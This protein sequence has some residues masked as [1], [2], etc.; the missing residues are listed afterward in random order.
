M[1]IIFC[2][3][4]RE[5]KLYGL[6]LKSNRQAGSRGPQPS[7]REAVKPEEEAQPLSLIPDLLAQLSL[8]RTHIGRVNRVQGLM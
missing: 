8:P 4:K 6:Y 1:E 5:T 3:P 2:K 7:R